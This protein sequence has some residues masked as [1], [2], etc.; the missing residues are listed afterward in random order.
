VTKIVVMPT[1][2]RM[3]TS[4]TRTS[5]AELGVQVRQGLV[6]QQDFGMDHQRPRQGHAL[7]LAAGQLAG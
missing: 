7:L 2:F 1:D 4:S 5:L 6:E 3:P